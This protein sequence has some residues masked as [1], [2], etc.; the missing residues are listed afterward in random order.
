M[1][2]K[3][4]RPHRCATAPAPHRARV[5][6]LLVLRGRGYHGEAL[7][8]APPVLLRRRLG[9]IQM[10]AYTVVVHIV[11]P[12]VVMEYIVM[13]VAKSGR[14]LAAT[15]AHHDVATCNGRFCT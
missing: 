12:Y 15:P 7:R 4:E 14:E 5:A 6:D 8:A 3:P 10:S 13:T 11:K 9:E 2:H 1:M